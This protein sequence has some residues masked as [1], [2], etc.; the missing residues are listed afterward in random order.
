MVGSATSFA[1]GG[2]SSLEPPAPVS[3]TY[4]PATRTG[5]INFNAPVTYTGT[6]GGAVLRVR[7]TDQ[8]RNVVSLAV[9]GSSQVTATFATGFTVIPGPNGFTY[10]GVGSPLQGSTGLAVAPFT[11]FPYTLV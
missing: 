11:D 9:T 4:A 7:H 5:V 6:I 3:A 8:R 1:L 2:L 10:T